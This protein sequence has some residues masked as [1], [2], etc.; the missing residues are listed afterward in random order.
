MKLYK[1]ICCAWIN[2]IFAKTFSSKIDFTNVSK[3]QQIYCYFTERT[4]ES[5][6]CKRRKRKHL[7]DNKYIHMYSHRHFEVLWIFILYVLSRFVL[8]L[9]DSY[10]A[11]I[12]PY[13]NNTF[14]I[15]GNEKEQQQIK[16]YKKIVGRVDFL[17]GD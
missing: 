1:C 17:A 3:I 13:M 16:F 14:P 8:S 10:Y 12:P 9:K 11:Y 7:F 15:L 4:L 5:D 6:L 2:R